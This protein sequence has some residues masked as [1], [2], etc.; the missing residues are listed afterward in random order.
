MSSVE[1][2]RKLKSYGMWQ[3]VG[4]AFKDGGFTKGMAILYAELDFTRAFGTKKMADGAWR[5]LVQYLV[6]QGVEEPEA[7]QA[8]INASDAV[9]NRKYG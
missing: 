8:L 7:V 5:S 6:D 4:S 1:Q 9:K 2:T 3:S